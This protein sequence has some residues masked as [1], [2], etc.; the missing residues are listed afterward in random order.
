MTVL[1]QELKNKVLYLTLNRPERANSLNPPLLVE[2][3]QILLNAQL[4]PKVRVIVLTG[5][6][7]KNFCTGIDVGSISSFSTEGKVNLA[8]VAGDIATL[9]FSGKPSIVVINGRAMGMGVVFASAADYRIMVDSCEWSMPEVTVGI[10][11][12]ASCVAIF[13]RVCGTGWTRRMLMTGQKFTP[14][15][16]LQANISDEICPRGELKEKT[17]QIVR[18]LKSYNSTNLKAIKMATI[19][20]LDMNY[21]DSIVLEKELSAWYEWQDSDSTIKTTL[22]NHSIQFNLTGDPQKLIEEFEQTNK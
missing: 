20:M 19:A 18:A 2:L 16:A 6:G 13:S 7:E 22:K 21:N 17:K 15:Q 14:Q 1:L 3:R 8:L 9:L 5:E 4:N 11:P 12:G 10:F